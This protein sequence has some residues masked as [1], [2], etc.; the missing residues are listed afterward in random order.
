M[1]SSW[2]GSTRAS[3]MLDQ[4]KN[5]A[6]P[7]I[8]RRTTAVEIWEDTEGAVDVFVSAVGTRGNYHGGG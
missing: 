7:E 2:S 4:F 5:P 6:N 1:P 8:H 3:V